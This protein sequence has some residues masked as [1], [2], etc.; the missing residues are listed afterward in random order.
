MEVSHILTTDDL[1]TEERRQINSLLFKNAISTT[2]YVASIKTGKIPCVVIDLD[3]RSCGQF[4]IIIS[5]LASK[6]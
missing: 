6:G 2:Y 5:L 4:K 1:P 3:R